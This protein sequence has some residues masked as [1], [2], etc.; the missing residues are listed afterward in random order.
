[1]E[2]EAYFQAIR[3]KVMA[4]RER[5]AQALRALGFAVLDSSANFLFVSHPKMEGKRLLDALRQRGILVRWW[6]DG[7]IRDWLRITIGTDGEME[8]LIRVL[9]GILS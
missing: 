3:G 4:T 6:D 2:D 5:T 8:E 7:P 9:R 1:M